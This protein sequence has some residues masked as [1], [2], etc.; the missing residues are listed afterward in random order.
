M[1]SGR[2]LA[3]AACWS[4]WVDFARFEVG[5]GLANFPHDGADL[6]R[7][8]RVA[9][10]RADACGR[11][12]VE[13]FGLGQLSFVELLDALLGGVAL[14]APRAGDVEAPRYIELPALDA[15]SVALSAVREASRGGETRVVATQHAGISIGGAVRAEVMRELEGVKLDVV[16]VSHVMGAEA[17]DVLVIVAQH[18]CYVMAGRSEGGL[19]RVV[20]AADPLLADVILRRL[21]EATMTRLLD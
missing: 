17:A 21:G 15:I 14:R 12:V 8:L 19:V 4:N 2:R 13:T 10:H 7:L 11:S 18:A 9:K 1:G 3:A 6:S 20:H 5:M 16:E